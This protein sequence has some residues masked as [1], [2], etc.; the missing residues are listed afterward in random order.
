[1]RRAWFGVVCFLAGVG[2]GAW[3]FYEREVVVHEVAVYEVPCES[4]IWA[5]DNP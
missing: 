4:P 1:M 5:L 3:A 2:M